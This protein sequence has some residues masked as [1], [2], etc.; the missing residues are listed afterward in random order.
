MFGQHLSKSLDAEV[1]VHG[2]GKPRLE[3][4]ASI[5]FYHGNKVQK[6]MLHL[7]IGDVRT[8]DLVGTVNDDVPQ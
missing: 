6:T 8:Q 1:Q 5:L 4:R 7:D 3:D 2:L